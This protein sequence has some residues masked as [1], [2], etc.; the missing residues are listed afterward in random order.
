MIYI[1]LPV[2][3]AETTGTDYETF[4]PVLDLLGGGKQCDFIFSY[5]NLSLAI[6]TN[7]NY[8][9]CMASLQCYLEYVISKKKLSLPRATARTATCSSEFGRTM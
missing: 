6:H 8:V 4:N 5:L 2:E 1:P 9:P 7:S 3:R